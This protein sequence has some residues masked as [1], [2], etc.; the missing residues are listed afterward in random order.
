MPDGQVVSAPDA[1]AAQVM[2]SVMSG[3]SVTDAFKQVGVDLAP[4]GTPVTDPVDPNTMP[5][6]SVGRFESR[7]PVM[8]MGNGKIW[9][10]GQLQPIGALGSSSDF[11]G[12][13]KPPTAAVPATAPPAP[14]GP[15]PAV[16]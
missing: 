8:A 15:P 9:M 12:W 4:P 1:R 11:L 13:S 5:P 10:D 6:T 16:T 2:R 14:S 3:T 7:E